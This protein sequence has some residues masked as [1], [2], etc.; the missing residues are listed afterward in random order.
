MMRKGQF[1]F[2][3][4]GYR[5]EV[6]IRKIYRSL[7]NLFCRIL[8]WY[9]KVTEGEESETPQSQIMFAITKY[10]YLWWC[11]DSVRIKYRITTELIRYM[12][13]FLFY[14]L[15]PVLHSLCTPSSH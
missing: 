1:I 10:N 6:T 12:H 2:H 4:T 11:Y 3:N 5:T 7:S 9:R 8:L 13:Y 15:G 14:V